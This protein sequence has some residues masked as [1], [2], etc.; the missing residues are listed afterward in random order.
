MGP[1]SMSLRETARDH[2]DQHRS[3][4]LIDLV[5]ACSWVT[6]V[7]ILFSVLNSPQWAYYLC[8]LSGVVAYYG[9]FTSL[10]IARNNSSS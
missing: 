1:P 3:D 6:M 8:M 4:M 10:V 7:T 2:I 9:F 5:F